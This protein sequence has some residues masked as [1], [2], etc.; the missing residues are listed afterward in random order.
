MYET[1]GGYP[2]V[3]DGFFLYIFLYILKQFL[4]LYYVIL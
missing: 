4:K 1:E 2:K 3:T